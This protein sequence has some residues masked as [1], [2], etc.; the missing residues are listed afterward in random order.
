M[1]TKQWIGDNLYIVEEEV[2]EYIE[3]ME[4]Q[5]EKHQWISVCYCGGE[6]DA[7]GRD[8][9]TKEVT[10]ECSKCGVQYYL[11]D[12]VWRESNSKRK[13]KS[14]ALPE[15][16]DSATLL[17]NCKWKEKN[18]SRVLCGCIGVTAIECSKRCKFA[19]PE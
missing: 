7:I 5:L 11:A 10:F 12:C 6:F 19:E 4:A 15:D 8:Y 16:I 17:P 9:R 3:D 1:S 13:L 18:G 2:A 14:I